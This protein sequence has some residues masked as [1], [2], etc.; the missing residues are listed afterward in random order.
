MTSIFKQRYSFWMCHNLSGYSINK[1]FIRHT[2]EFI[3]F[4]SIETDRASFIML[5]WL[6]S[7][8]LFI[9]FVFDH[10]IY[11][12]P[13]LWLSIMTA[14]RVKYDIHWIPSNQRRNKK[15]L[16]TDL[17]VVIFSARNIDG[18]S[19]TCCFFGV[20]SRLLNER[21]RWKKNIHNEKQLL[22]FK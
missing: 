20:W 8:S 6:T 11:L 7:F 21:K 17:V 18:F 13:C 4:D 12:Y 1:R 15:W 10:F 16:Q 19:I 14:D 3:D 9:S 2:D 22:C 5:W